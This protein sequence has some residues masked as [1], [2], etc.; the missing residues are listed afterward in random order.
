MS[1]FTIPLGINLLEVIS[2]RI[3][4]KGTVILTVKSK[5]TKDSFQFLVALLP[6]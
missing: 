2:Q 1:N 6:F 4:T 5:N 3:D